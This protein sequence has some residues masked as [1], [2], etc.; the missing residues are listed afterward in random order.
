MN[1]YK[2][3]FEYEQATTLSPDFVNTVFI[4]DH[5]FTRLIQSN[6]NVFIVGE[7]GSGKSMTLLYNSLAVK[8][9]Q[10]TD[11]NELAY[12]GIYVPC[13]TALTHKREYEL[14]EDVGFRQVV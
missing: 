14:F 5:S 10:Q 3:P 11:A 2:N 13:N 7:R 1:S 6:R 9:V 12:I 4:E 8:R